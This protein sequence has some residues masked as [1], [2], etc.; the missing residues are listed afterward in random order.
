MKL[1]GRKPRTL[2]GVTRAGETGGQKGNLVNLKDRVHALIM[3]GIIVKASG[4]VDPK[5]SL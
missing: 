5:E 4:S 3:I 1:E 2:T